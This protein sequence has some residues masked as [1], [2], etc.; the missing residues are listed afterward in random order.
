V[1]VRAQEQ[2]RHFLVPYY[3]FVARSNKVRVAKKRPTEISS[4]LSFLFFF[5]I[6]QNRSKKGSNEL[7]LSCPNE[8]NQ[9]S[10]RK[11]SRAEPDRGS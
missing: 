7:E 8:T 3:V 5:F 9:A 6:D 10:P 11:P 1:M 2:Q 4:P